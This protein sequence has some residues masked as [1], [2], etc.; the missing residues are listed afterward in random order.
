VFRGKSTLSKCLLLGATLFA[1]GSAWVALR[2][3]SLAGSV[4]PR[5]G[6]IVVGPADVRFTRDA[7]CDIRARLSEEAYRE[8]IEFVAA[9][10]ET[11]G[12]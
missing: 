7:L 9:C 12:R 3:P 2:D 5:S 1:L 6:D 11:R 4:A 10:D 8:A